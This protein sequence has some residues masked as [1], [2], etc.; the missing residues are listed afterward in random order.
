M[1]DGVVDG[2]ADGVGGNEAA[3]GVVVHLAQQLEE[4]VCALAE[5]C[6]DEGSSAVLVVE[7]VAEGAS[8]VTEG[9]RQSC[10]GEAVALER[11]QGALAVVGCVV[12]QASADEG[13]DAEHLAV[14]WCAE[15]VD[16][17]VGIVAHLSAGQLVVA[18]LGGDDVEDVGRCLTV[19]DVPLRGVAVVGLCGKGFTQRQPLAAG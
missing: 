8:H 11:L 18:G 7:V 2:D 6:E 16:I 10:G 15:A 17:G 1:G 5:A 12:V 19:G 9:Q 14:E 13:V 4:D 3:I